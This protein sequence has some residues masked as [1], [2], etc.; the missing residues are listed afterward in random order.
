MAVRQFFQE[1]F[2]LFLI[3]EYHA[4]IDRFGGDAGNVSCRCVVVVGDRMDLIHQG[5]AE[6]E[7]PLFPQLKAD[8]NRILFYFPEK[9]FDGRGI[10]GVFIEHLII[11]KAELAVE[12]DISVKGKPL[13]N[14]KTVLS[15]SG[16]DK[17]TYSLFLQF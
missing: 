1:L 10:Q 16:C 14:L 12:G 5:I 4:L 15:P 9:Q 17:E 7:H 3:H 2:F 8:G 11:G 6:I 13:E